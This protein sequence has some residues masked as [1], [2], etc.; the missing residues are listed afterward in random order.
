MQFKK[1]ITPH[2]QKLRVFWEFER[3]FNKYDSEC[4][5]KEEML[6]SVLC[7]SP[8]IFF[9]SLEEILYVTGPYPEL[10]AFNLKK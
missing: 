8:H 3:W 5:A 4:Q 2:L 1:W 7:I 6:G 10:V 9:V